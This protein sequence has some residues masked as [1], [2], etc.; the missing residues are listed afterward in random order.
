MPCHYY[1]KDTNPSWQY[2]NCTNYTSQRLTVKES[3]E[4]SQ[5]MQKWFNVSCSHVGMLPGVLE[6]YSYNTSYFA[7]LTF[8]GYWI[9]ARKWYEAVF[10]F[11]RICDLAPQVWDPAPLSADPAPNVSDLPPIM[12]DPILSDM[13]SHSQCWT[14][15]VMSILAPTTILRCER[16]L[17]SFA[18]FVGSSKNFV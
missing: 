5:M 18:L 4:C 10:K 12:S 8:R 17:I 3:E 2:Q 7:Q 1:R 11:G 6:G 13:W 9:A 14:R 16:K 15:Y